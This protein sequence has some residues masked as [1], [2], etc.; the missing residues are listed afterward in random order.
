VGASLGGLVGRYAAAPSRQGK[1]PRRLRIARLFTI[2]SPHAGAKLAEAVP[3]TDF[4][5]ELRPGSEF[6]RYVAQY[7]ASARYEIYPYVHLDDEIVGDRNAAPPGQNPYWLANAAPLPPHMGAILDE[8]IL[9]DISRRL[10]GETPY[11]LPPAGPL[12]APSQN[13]P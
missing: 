11:T 8:R 12:P 9:A 2:S 1:S 3:L 4:G 6:L 10:R 13:R 7:D 5:H